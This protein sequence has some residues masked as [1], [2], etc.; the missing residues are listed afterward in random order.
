MC[1]YVYGGLWIFCVWVSVLQEDLCSQGCTL[2]LVAHCPGKGTSL[3][4]RPGEMN[5][6]GRT[7]V[8]RLLELVGRLQRAFW[9]A[10]WLR[11]GRHLAYPWGTASRDAVAGRAFGGGRCVTTVLCGRSHTQAGLPAACLPGFPAHRAWGSSHQMVVP[12][13]LFLC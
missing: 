6:T 2:P 4:P 11:G 3:T 12:W 10:C 13:P 8:F 1:L 5:S 7:D 9:P